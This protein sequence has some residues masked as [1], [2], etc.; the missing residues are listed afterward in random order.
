M[1]DVDVSAVLIGLSRRPKKLRGLVIDRWTIVGIGHRRSLL[2]LVFGKV[3][4]MNICEV[5][6]DLDRELTTAGFPFINRRFDLG[7]PAG[8]DVEGLKAIALSVVSLGCK[9]ET[10]V[11]T[12]LD[13]GKLAGRDLLPGL[14][15]LLDYLE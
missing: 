5:V 6:R 3:G 8:L 13:P 2:H 1:D 14:D 12:N 11:H 4:K 9:P 10:P 15:K 7:A